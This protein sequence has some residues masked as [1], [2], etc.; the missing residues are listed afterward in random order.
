VTDTNAEAVSALWR[1]LVASQ[2]VGAGLNQSL[3]GNSRR[4]R[5]RAK[6]HGARPRAS[7]ADLVGD[8][9]GG[10]DSEEDEAEDNDETDATTPLRAPFRLT[11]RFTALTWPVQAI[12]PMKVTPGELVLTESMLAFRA[13]MDEP[14]TGEESTTVPP[15]SNPR[16]IEESKRKAY[17]T[18]LLKPAKSRD[19]VLEAIAAVEIRRYHFQHVAIEVYTKDGSQYFYNLMTSAARAQFFDGLKRLRHKLGNARVF[20]RVRAWLCCACTVRR[21]VVS[22][23]VLAWLAAF[24]CSTSGCGVNQALAVPEHQQL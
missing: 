3:H 13:R 16:Q 18:S 6:S 2:A 14:N 22:F 10:S 19:I 9:S 24:G 8:V 21:P 12:T 23:C 11:E 17:A 1:D 20:S 7:P 5:G 4:Y 15:P